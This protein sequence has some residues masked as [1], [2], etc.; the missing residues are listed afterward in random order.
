MELQYRISH[1]ERVNRILK[2]R[3]K[4]FEELYSGGEVLENIL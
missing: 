2:E 4:N 1:E 3:I